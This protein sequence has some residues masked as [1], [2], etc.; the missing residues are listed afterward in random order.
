ML[1]SS[2]W[3][4]FVGQLRRHPWRVPGLGLTLLGM[5]GRRVAQRLRIRLQADVHRGFK[6]RPQWLPRVAADASAARDLRLPRLPLTGVLPE[7][8]PAALRADDPEAYFA[9]HRW[10]ACALALGDEVRARAAF[11]EVRTWLK[12]PPDRADAAWESYSCCE[13]VVNLALL[14]AAHPTL[15]SEIDGAEL[16][17]FFSESAAWID[18]H[19]E[20]YGAVRTNNHFLNNGRALV[21]A[22]CVLGH[23]A[24]LMTGLSIVERFAPE[25]FA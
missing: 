25:L 15:P 16:Q 9:R 17:T 20:Y 5:I 24:W 4:L 6:Q 10:S 8:L 21:V 3:P 12:Q 14:L 2:E 23:D 22:G 11:A 7:V 19:L 18:D 1:D 13:R